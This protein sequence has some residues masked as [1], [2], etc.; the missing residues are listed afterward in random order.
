MSLYRIATGGPPTPAIIAKIPENIPNKD[1]LTGSIFLFKLDALA[2][3]VI[4]KKNIGIIDYKK[5]E[6]KMNPMKVLSTVVNR[7][8]SLIEISAIPYSNDVIGLQDLYL[9]LDN[10]SS[11]YSW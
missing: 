4:V 2:E 8:A 9:Q 1:L 10:K 5:G 7:G 3:P 6:I 11:T